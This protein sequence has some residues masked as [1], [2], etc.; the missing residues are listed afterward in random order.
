MAL[1]ERKGHTKAAV[2]L[3]NKM[4]RR[5]WA[6]EHHGTRFDP[7]TSAGANLASPDPLAIA[8]HRSTASPFQPP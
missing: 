6:A 4:A 7:N 2:A 8:L 1:A 3:A 5:L